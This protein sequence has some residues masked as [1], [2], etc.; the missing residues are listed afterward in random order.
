MLDKEKWVALPSKVWQLL[1]KTKSWR[2]F[3]GM[4]QCR[5]T[6]FFLYYISNII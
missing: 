3:D 4:Q 6:F 2:R 5:I 1:E